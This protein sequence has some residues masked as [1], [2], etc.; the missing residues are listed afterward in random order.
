MNCPN[1][2]TQTDYKHLTKEVEDGIKITSSVF[3]CPQCGIEVGTQETAGQ[4]QKK[5]EKARK[6]RNMLN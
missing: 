3:V 6:L 1:C 5:L 2:K 4:V